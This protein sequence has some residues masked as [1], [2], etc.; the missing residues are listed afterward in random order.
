MN[1]GYDCSLF[2]FLLFV[3]YT[4]LVP[5]IVLQRSDMSTITIKPGAPCNWQVLFRMDVA[6]LINGLCLGAI[7]QS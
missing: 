1:A 6:C 5:M 7:K 2:S 4:S 3:S